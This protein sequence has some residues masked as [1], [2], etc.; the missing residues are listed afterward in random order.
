LAQETADLLGPDFQLRRA[1]VR[2][3]RTPSDAAQPFTWVIAQRAGKPAHRS[4]A[5]R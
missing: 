3:H 2:E 5:V 1:Q 4:A